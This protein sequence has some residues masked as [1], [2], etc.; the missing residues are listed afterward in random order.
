[1]FGETTMT[2][3]NSPNLQGEGVN[4]PERHSGN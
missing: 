3:G 2:R 4:L 1:M